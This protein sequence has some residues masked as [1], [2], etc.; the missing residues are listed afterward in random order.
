MYFCLYIGNFICDKMWSRVTCM[1][2]WAE[3]KMIIHVLSLHDNTFFSSNDLRNVCECIIRN[4]IKRTY[5]VYPLMFEKK[6]ITF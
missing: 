2:Y 6:I 1:C 4:Q 3:D 5:F